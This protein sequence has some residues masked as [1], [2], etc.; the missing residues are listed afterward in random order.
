MLPPRHRCPWFLGGLV[1][2]LTAGLLLIDFG[3]T[4]APPRPITSLT[5][6]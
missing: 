6:Q 4:T 1:L 5:S 2:G 3:R